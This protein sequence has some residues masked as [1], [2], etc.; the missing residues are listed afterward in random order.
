MC[1]DMVGCYGSLAFYTSEL[2]FFRSGRAQFL[3][4]TRLGWSTWV[5]GGYGV[6]LFLLYCLWM[7]EV[8]A[9]LSRGQG[10]I[11][12]TSL[13]IYDFAIRVIWSDILKKVNRL[14]TIFLSILVN[15]VNVEYFVQVSNLQ[16][17]KEAAS[18]CQCCRWFSMLATLWYL[19]L[20]RRQ[21]PP[22]AMRHLN[23]Y[24]IPQACPLPSI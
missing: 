18:L 8:L 23:D 5:Y 15:Y 1:Y 9:C 3:D 12:G 11:V 22:Q 2:R 4:Q 24:A 21:S 14:F 13:F 17:I 6:L 19:A 10:R 16:M 7:L 20:R